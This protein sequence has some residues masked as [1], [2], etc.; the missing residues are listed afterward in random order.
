MS[1][2]DIKKNHAQKEEVKQVLAAN[3]A[4]LGL[5]KISPGAITAGLAE[6]LGALIASAT[7]TDEKMSDVLTT[8]A[9]LAR[10]SAHET[11]AKLISMGLA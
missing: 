2:E 9:D 11:K 5:R 7:K 10:Q 4:L 1:Q 6:I 3:I 8:S